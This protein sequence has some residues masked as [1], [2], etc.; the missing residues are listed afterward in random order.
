MT[1]KS[2]FSLVVFAFLSL[3]SNAQEIGFPII[4]NYTP[5]EFNGTPQVL[6]AI[7][8]NR[9]VM[10]FGCGSSL[11]E[12]DGVN[13]CNIS[14]S[15][16]VRFLDFAMDKGGKI[17]VSALD[18][19]GYLKIDKKGNTSYKSLANLLSDTTHKIGFV[20][21][22]E[23]TSKF[24]YFIT[25]DAIF[26]Y[27]PDTEKIVIIEPDKNDGFLDG[28][29]YNDVLYVQ[30]NKNGLI[31]FENGEIK[32][33]PK[34]EFFQNKNIFRTALPF[35]ANSLLIPTRTEGLYIYQPEKD[36][37]P[38]PFALSNNDFVQDNNIYNA[39]LFKKESFV[40]ASINKGALLFDSKGKILQQYKESNLLQNN[41]VRVVM[42]DTS[43]NLWMGLDNGISKT[44]YRLDLSYWDKNASLKGIAYNVIRFN[45]TIYIATSV[46][47]Y[48]INKNNQLQEVKNIPVGQNWCFLEYK[49]NKSLLA[50]SRYGIYEIKGDS[51]IL[52]CAGTHFAKLYQSAKNPQRVFSS[53]LPDLISIRF[54]AG[55]WVYEGKWDG[56]DDEV[57]GII[58]DESGDLWLGTYRNGVIRVT[59]NSEDITKPKKI[60]YYKK[61]DG[62][63]SLVDILP[64]RFKNK[65]IWGSDK[66]LYSY[67]PKI[68]RFE[69]FCELGNFFCNGSRSVYSLKE[70]PDGKIWICPK[71]NKS[72]DIGYLQPNNKGGYDW[73]YAPFRRIPEMFL[74]A[75]YVEP[76][77]II[78]IGGSEGLYKYDM[79]LDTKHYAQHFNCLIR[80]ITVA[81]DS[82]IYGG[83]TVDT[84]IS[85]LKYRFNDI[86]FEFAAPFFDQEEKTLYSHKLE[87]YDMEWSKWA[88]QTQKEYTN[89]GEGSYTFKVKARNVY[90]VESETSTYQIIIL[91]PFY[92]TWWA[93]SIYLML[94]V[95]FIIIVIKY[96]TRHLRAQKE[97]LKQ[98][99]KEGTAEILQQKDKIQ[100]HE[101][102]LQAYNEEL[103]ATNEELNNQREELETTLEALK[104]AQIHLVQSEKMA[105]LGLLASGVA[106][107]INNP[108]NFIQGGVTGIEH[109]FEENPDEHKSSVEFFINAIKEGVHRAVEIVSG[110][111]HFSRNGNIISCNVNIHTVINNCLLML[112]NKTK[113]R[114]E[115]IKDYTE[116]PYTLVG[117][118][119][120][121]HQA[122]LNVLA[123][124]VQSIH[125]IGT[126]TINTAIKDES[127]KISVTD[128]GC[129]ISE[130][131][132]LRIFDP[133][134]TTMEPGKGTGLGLFITFN[135]IQEHKGTIEFESELGKG[136]TVIIKLPINS[137]K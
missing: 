117:N 107:E 59:P 73:A 13:W 68:D 53:A 43:Q 28:F 90:D 115:I 74:E 66:G 83:N 94:F 93:Y 31:K 81:V 30:L 39:S 133:F 5:K 106:H 29:V 11:L 8:D 79:R 84:A 51:A 102:E 27:S 18:D 54:D 69:P 64:F 127:I 70:M 101:V 126:I 100:A 122:M 48:F 16:H 12:Y 82:T 87:G 105:S 104:K 37:A 129:G 67:N 103:K 77:G 22:I 134:F 44:E 95:L 32:H 80:K 89:L 63:A 25:Y 7:Q 99:V 136:T 3:F 75:F 24:V 45:G 26:Q 50:G 41:T 98:L 58:E 86:K 91:P 57:R 113:E 60:Q 19:F 1:P 124:A 131:N 20:W 9:G 10:Y 56:I 76:T 125:D 78:W 38:K 14:K 121:L 110:L 61:K 42:A 128:T 119:G 35:N 36:T 71:E 72:E 111:N 96:Y 46:K 116:T 49:E 4:R 135:I 15:K 34:S 40:L 108:L 23:L 88:R 92:R 114:I 137:S 62:F 85:E 33:A 55:K 65:I 6:S 132:L 97:H 109:Y 2:L 118:E 52:I 47:M 120:N 123:N 112:Q 130:E 17:Y 21:T